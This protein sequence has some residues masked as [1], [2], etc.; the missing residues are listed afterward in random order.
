MIHIKI[1]QTGSDGNCMV[2]S[3]GHTRIMIDAGVA[4]STLL[5]SG[6]M[7]SEIDFL[8]ISHDHGDHNK[9]AAKISNDY[10][11]PVIGSQGTLL[12]TPGIQKRL[13]ANL[14]KTKTYGLNTVKLKPFKIIHD[15]A[16]PFGFLLQNEIMET[17][18]FIPE[19]GTLKNFRVNS[20]FY[21]LEVNYCEYDIKKA[22]E[23]G[24]INEALYKRIT[25]RRGHL[26]LESALEFV[27]TKPNAKFLF[28]HM[29][30]NHFNYKR[31]IPDNC[32]LAENGKEYMFGTEVPY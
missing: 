9:Y 29:S 24:K 28:H 27:E 23:E 30:K 1:Y 19:T 25:S 26:S 7:F 14:N 16:E 13:R 8:F 21:I 10:E 32:Q 12:N 3:D 22:L 18:T 6:I 20:D 4:P 31:R 2:L 11:I 17:I 15:A 5:K